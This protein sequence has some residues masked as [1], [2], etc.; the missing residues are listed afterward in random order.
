MLKNKIYRNIES[1]LKKFHNF[2]K[3]SKKN[4]LLQKS[5]QSAIYNTSEK[6]DVLFL[7]L[8]FS[9]KY[10]GFDQIIYYEYINEFIPKQTFNLSL[11]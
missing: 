6:N 11:T 10:K 9:N 1:V 7:L 4:I 2:E 5:I 8:V 3:R